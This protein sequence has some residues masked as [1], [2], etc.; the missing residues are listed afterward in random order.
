MKTAEM[1]RGDRGELIP[2]FLARSGGGITGIWNEKDE[3]AVAR[4]LCNGGLE[5]ENAE[6]LSLSSRPPFIGIGF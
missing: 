6:G 3:R 5:R 2:G 1:E 4:A